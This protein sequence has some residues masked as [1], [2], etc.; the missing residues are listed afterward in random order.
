MPNPGIHT[1][2]W[3][4]ESQWRTFSFWLVWSTLQ[5]FRMMVITTLK[6][7]GMTFDNNG[8][9][10]NVW[11]GCRRLGIA[12]SRFWHWFR[13]VIKLWDNLTVSASILILGFLKW[14][15]AKQQWLQVME[16]N[17]TINSE[18][19]WSLYEVISCRSERFDFEE[20]SPEKVKDKNSFVFYTVIGWEYGLLNN[21]LSVGAMYTARFAEPKTLNELISATLRPKN[22]LNAAISY[23]PIQA[24]GKINWS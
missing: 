6:G 1:R 4:Y 19:L 10:D 5:L 24:S 7:G 16:E 18:E 17:V 11:F 21:K 13:Q 8:M 22:W 15:E 12:G 3:D 9:I 14:K 2:L 23:S 20:G